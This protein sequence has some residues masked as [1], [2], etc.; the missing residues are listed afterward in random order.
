MKNKRERKINAKLTREDIL[1]GSRC[2][3]IFDCPVARAI[4]RALPGGWTCAVGTSETDI[5]SED[6]YVCTFKNPPETLR[7]IKA[8]EQHGRI[9]LPHV[10]EKY[11]GQEIHLRVEKEILGKGQ[12]A[13][14]EEVKR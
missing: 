8:F 2:G 9:T 14:P 6:G 1:E 4:N 12:E 7:F 13:V 11:A 5:Y 3:D 10:V